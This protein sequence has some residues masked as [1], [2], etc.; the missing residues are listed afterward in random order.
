MKFK[1][2]LV[3]EGAE[4][5]LAH[6]LIA[7]NELNLSLTWYLNKRLNSKKFYI[8]SIQTRRD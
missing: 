4:W 6:S 2:F 7:P 8:D 5:K 3:G 1:F